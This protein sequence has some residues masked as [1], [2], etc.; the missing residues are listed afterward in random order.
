M[1]FTVLALNYFLQKFMLVVRCSSPQPLY[2]KKRKKDEDK[3]GVNFI[4][5]LVAWLVF[6][7]PVSLCIT[8]M[9]DC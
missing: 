2:S 6:I 1:G 8:F 3:E 9:I 4:H 7:F 5:L